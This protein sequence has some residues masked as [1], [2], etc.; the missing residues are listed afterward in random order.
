M[1]GLSRFHNKNAVFYSVLYVVRY[2]THPHINNKSVVRH[3]RRS[4]L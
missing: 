3:G 2:M 4:L 1:H